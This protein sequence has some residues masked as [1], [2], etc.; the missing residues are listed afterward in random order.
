MWPMEVDIHVMM[1]IHVVMMLERAGFGAAMDLSATR[2]DIGIG[3]AQAAMAQTIDPLCSIGFE[4]TS[5]CAFCAGRAT[6]KTAVSAI[7]PAVPAM[8]GREQRRGERDHKR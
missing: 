3:M 6:V 2:N 7:T 1:N 4:M 8:I 5:G